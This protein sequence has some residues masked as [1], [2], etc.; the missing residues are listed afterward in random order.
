[1]RN[2]HNAHMEAS[3][4]PR[5]APAGVSL[6]KSPHLLRLAPDSH[7]VALIREGRRGAFE[8]VYDRHHRGILSFC[9]HMLGDPQE[10]EDA[11]Q[12]TFL[13]AYN[14]LISSHKQIHLR[15]WLFTIARNRCYSILRARREQPAADIDEAITEGLATQ[16]QRR[17]DLRDL[18]LDM[19]R[20]PEDQRAA[21]VLAELESLSHEQIGEALGVPREKVKALVFQARESLVASRAARET[22]CAEIR[23]QLAT[24]R[25]GGLRR[26][27]LRRHLREC[28]GC[29]DFKKQIDRQRHQLAILLPVVP[30]I[31]LKEGVLGA[32]IGGGASVG[33]AGGGLMLSSVVKS[34]LAKV[35]A[36]AVLAGVGTAGT[37]VATNG[38]KFGSH[39]PMAGSRVDRGASGQAPE[40]TATL[41]G[42][43][44]SLPTHTLPVASELTPATTGAPQ[45]AQ[46]TLGR[47]S[48]G[49][50]FAPPGSGWLTSIVRGA[51]WTVTG[52]AGGAGR[53]NGAASI[54]P[55]QTSTGTSGPA[56][57]QG[58]PWDVFGSGTGITVGQRSSSSRHGGI[59]GG[60][61][62]SAT[63]RSSPGGSAR[64]QEGGNGSYSSSSG[65][66]G[67]GDSGSGASSAG[68][69]G[70]DGS[71]GSGSSAGPASPSP[72]GGADSSASSGASSGSS[73][74]SSSSGSD[75][76]GSSSGSGSSAGSGTGDPTAGGGSSSG[77][78]GTGGTGSSGGSNGSGGAPVAPLGA[79]D[80]SGGQSASASSG[81][82]SGSSGSSGTASVPQTVATPPSAAGSG[83]VQSP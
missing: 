43:T 27:N 29:R 61:G 17:Q 50:S 35:V 34:G 24:Q 12:H 6:L 45:N 8:A 22:D 48:G 1:V 79:T 30:T 68:G 62:D 26:T 70:S 74:S 5:L 23:E 19:R 16:V 51:T 42:S 46:S 66:A 39:T 40:G 44:E 3:A 78:G 64:G 33:I 82:T 38:I 10:A 63:G 57:P 75:G 13:S 56:Q 47:A 9:R 69:S 28:A 25:G 58:S 32:T 37:I 31:A 4:V 20:L 18:V 71:S 73:S 77:S 7:L 83:P 76:S 67:G 65:S 72:P 55:A 2:E 54:A 52:L 53:A 60:Y 41:P 80:T 21:L 59:D 49:V 14:D 36:G 11:V 81:S 15:A